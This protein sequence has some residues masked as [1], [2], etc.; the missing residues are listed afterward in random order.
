MNVFAE[1]KTNEE[2]E[3]Y[4]DI[5]GKEILSQKPERKGT[6]RNVVWIFI[7]SFNTTIAFLYVIPYYSQQI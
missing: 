5:L 6:F 2:K 1:M 4:E 3:I 7:C